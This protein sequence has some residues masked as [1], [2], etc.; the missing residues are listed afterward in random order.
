MSQ[1]TLTVRADASDRPRASEP[2]IRVKEDNERVVST[3]GNS[4]KRW[5]AVA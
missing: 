3:F 5:M 1:S 2:G 4:A